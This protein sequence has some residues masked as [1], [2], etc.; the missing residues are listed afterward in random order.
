MTYRVGL[1]H[2]GKEINP[3]L[4]TGEDCGRT[5]AFVFDVFQTLTIPTRTFPVKV[6]RQAS[7]AMI[8]PYPVFVIMYS[9]QKVTRW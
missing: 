5:P 8:W 4:T 6:D 9:T 2:W 3:T 1:S 7:T